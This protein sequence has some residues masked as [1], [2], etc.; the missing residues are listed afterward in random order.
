MENEPYYMLELAH[1]KIT[2]KESFV[3]E[4]I[5]K[6]SK[7]HS[8]DLWDNLLSTLNLITQDKISADQFMD[9][10]NNAYPQLFPS[11]KYNVEGNQIEVNINKLILDS[12][13]NKCKVDVP[14]TLTQNIDFL[15]DL[16]VHPSFE[17]YNEFYSK[18]SKEVKMNDRI[19]T[20]LYESGQINLIYNATI[21]YISPQVCDEYNNA[22]SEG[23]LDKILSIVKKEK[24]RIDFIETFGYSKN[25]HDHPNAVNCG[26]SSD[27][28]IYGINGE[29]YAT[30]FKPKYIEFINEVPY[31]SN[32]VK[33]EN[34]MYERIN[35]KDMIFFYKLSFHFELCTDRLH[36]I[37]ANQ[38]KDD[39][40]IDINIGK[41][42]DIT[43]FRSIFLR[44]LVREVAIH[45]NDTKSQ[46]IFQ[47][48]L[49]NSRIASSGVELLVF[50]AREYRSKLPLGNHTFEELY[51]TFKDIAV[52]KL[53]KLEIYRK[54]HISFGKSQELY[55][56][57]LRM[58]DEN[59]IYFE[60]D[61][62][63]Q[64]YLDT[65]F[66]VGQ[67]LSHQKTK[68]KPNNHD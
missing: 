26:I 29:I 8:L 65:L 13:L 2:T 6:G 5:N 43:K 1:D 56:E 39:F 20:T 42:F 51:S 14:K 67:D 47:D 11:K 40:T 12:L 66:N 3:T 10:I 61:P 28:K 18:A 9:K 38:P 54:H 60:F 36:V 15:C 41:Q 53:N 52:N 4:L 19:I 24:A 33:I 37:V 7:I 64:E 50:K 59:I 22:I 57:L 68:H 21:R 31:I 44:S 32:L 30:D 25:N 17:Y 62:A 49:C 27:G 16:F 46:L 55:Y 23:D 48:L 34:P 63:E 35:D 58:R 45:C